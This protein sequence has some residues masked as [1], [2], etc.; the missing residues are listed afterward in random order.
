MYK[1]KYNECQD[2]LKIFGD[3]DESINLEKKTYMKTVRF[4]C[5]KIRLL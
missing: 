3:G 2:V 1:G 4:F 5:L